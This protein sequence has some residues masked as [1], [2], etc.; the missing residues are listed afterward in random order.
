MLADEII[1]HG[2]KAADP[3]TAVDIRIGLGYTVVL[4]EDGRCVT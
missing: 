2:L 3:H 1:E 4:L